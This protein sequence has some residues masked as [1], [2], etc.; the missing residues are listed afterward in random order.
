M[1]CDSREPGG[2]HGKVKPVG[3]DPELVDYGRKDA[4]HDVIMVRPGM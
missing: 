4:Q 3:S 1:V 2:Q